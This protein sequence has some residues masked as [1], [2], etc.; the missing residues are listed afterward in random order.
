M[1]SYFTV[2]RCLAGFLLASS[3]TLSVSAE[4]LKVAV[5]DMTVLL[6]EF[7]ETK[8]AEEEDTVERDDIKKDDAERISAIKALEEEMRRL[9]GSAQD[10]SLADTKRQEIGKQYAEVEQTHVALRRERQEFIERR[11]RQLNQKMVSRMNDIRMTIAKAVQD[12]AATLEVDYVFD[13][14]GLTTSQVPF[15]LYIRNK[16]DIT[17]EVLEILNKDA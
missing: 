3:F 17:Q 6:T 16:K 10:P 1:K 15:I 7:H 13:S 11:G 2:A 8:S 14:S 4:P 9:A 5:V 12:H